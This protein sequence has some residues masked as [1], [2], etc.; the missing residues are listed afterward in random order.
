MSITQW[1]DVNP[2]FCRTVLGTLSGFICGLTD[3]FLFSYLSAH[4]SFG[5]VYNLVSYLI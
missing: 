5:L 3:C 4:S 1:A 2:G